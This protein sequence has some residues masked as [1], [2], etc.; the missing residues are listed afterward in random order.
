MKITKEI[1]GEIDA[2]ANRMG[3]DERKVASEMT[4]ASASIESGDNFLTKGRGEMIAPDSAY[5]YWRVWKQGRS[6]AD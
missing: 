4:S 3:E 5:Q 1:V 6:V 2:I